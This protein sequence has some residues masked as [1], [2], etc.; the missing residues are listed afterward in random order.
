V[1]RHG[2]LSIFALFL[3]LPLTSCTRVSAKSAAGAVDTVPVRAVLAEAQDVPLELSA[4]GSVEAAE[5]AEV[6]ARI[7]GQVRSVAFQEGQNV[8]KGQQLFTIDHEGFERQAAEQQAEIERDAAIEQQARAVV[9]RDE[10]GQKQSASE[11]D[12]ARKLGD[13]GVLSGQRVNQLVTTSDT[14]SAGLRSDQAAV[15]AATGA[16]RADRARLAQTQL[17]L[18]FSSVVAPISGRAGAAM[19]K[20]GN[21]VRENDTT[22]VSILQLAPIY[23]TFGI[24]EQSLAEVRQLS[25][26]GPLA[27]E[28]TSGAGTILTGQLTFIDNTVDATTGTIRLKANFP[29]ADGSLWPGEF[30][31][32]RLRLRTEK[33]RVV[34]PQSAIQ[35]G[36]DGKYVWLIQS[37]TAITRPVQELRA[38]KP[39]NGLEEAVIGSGIAPGQTIVTEGQLRLTPGARIALLDTPH[40]PPPRM[41]SAESR[42]RNNPN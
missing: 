41:S 15:E 2:M 38:Y 32:V 10:A 16:T 5:S 25:A 11:A 27:V 33:G 26:L 36:L 40:A 8:S 19:V 34:I 20:T 4:V 7:A 18:S 12:V 30:V 6:K 3:C 37:G 31:H 23:V 29:N 13:L 28:A 24:P 21:V 42:Q 14:A 1:N 17:Q 22:L 9:A 35:E 39:E